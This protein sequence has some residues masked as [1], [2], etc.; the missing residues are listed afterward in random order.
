MNVELIELTMQHHLGCP[1]PEGWVLC[2]CCQTFEGPVFHR[3]HVASLIAAEEMCEPEC[4]HPQHKV[5][6]ADLAL[7]IDGTSDA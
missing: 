6:R 2:L 7:V 3:R 1:S 5:E 4:R